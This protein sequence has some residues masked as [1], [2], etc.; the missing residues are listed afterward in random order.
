MSADLIERVLEQ[1]DALAVSHANFGYFDTTGVFRS[2]RYAVRHLKKAMT[3]GIAWLALPSG[4]S[5]ADDAIF[6]NRWVNPDAGY[7][8]SVVRLDPESCRTMPF[9][10]EGDGLLLVGEFTGAVADHCPRALLRAE[11]DRLAALGFD[12]FGAFELEGAVLAETVE[13]LREKRAADVAVVPG[14]ERV[15]SFVDQT[16][17]SGLIDD[18]LAC[19]ETMGMPLETAHAEFSDI[20]EVGMAPTTGLRIADNAGLYKAAAKIVAAKHDAYISFMARRSEKDQGCGAH[21]NVSLK[22]RD[23]AESVFFDADAQHRLTGTA[24]HFIGGLLTYLPELF[25]LLAPNL[26]SYKRYAPGIFTPLNNSW[27]INNRTVAL[28]VSNGTKGAARV[29][30]RPA[31]ADVCPHLALL[32]VCLAGRLGI[33]EKIDPPAPLTGNGWEAA[34]TGAPPFPLEFGAAIDAF[35]NSKVANTHIGAGFVEDFV[36]DRKWQQE[37]FAA[38]VTDWEMRTFSS[39]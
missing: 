13:S 4:M 23:S 7:S 39:L 26:N 34:E 38:T 31:G 29:E 12:L 33:E 27:S 19:C 9:D 21:I 5:P 25:L 22:D 6:T 30:V 36:T 8:D 3:E 32:A 18:L 11:I 16:G 15:Y 1:A 28:R 20:L 17:Q 37:T 14:W 35:A 24:C 10:S 2:K